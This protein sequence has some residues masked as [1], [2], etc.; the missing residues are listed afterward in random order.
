MQTN[1]LLRG[2]LQ[3]RLI[4]ATHSTLRSMSFSADDIYPCIGKIPRV[5]LRRDGVEFIIA[6]G[7]ELAKPYGQFCEEFT[8]IV[9]HRH[10]ISDEIA[11]QAANE[12]HERF[13]LPQ[14]IMAIGAK[15]IIIPGIE[16]HNRH[17]LN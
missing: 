14:L 16:N 7:T 2:E 11:E 9:G 13:S 10:E 12:W 15:G 17:E 4:L 1:D 6:I 5:M 3:Y 8:Y